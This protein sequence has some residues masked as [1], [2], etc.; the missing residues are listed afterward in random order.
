MLEFRLLHRPVSRSQPGI[1]DA[2]SAANPQ[3]CP[4]DRL[5]RHPSRSNTLYPVS[6]KRGTWCTRNFRRK[7]DR[8]TRQNSALHRELSMACH[9][10]D[11]EVYRYQ[12]RR[13]SLP[14]EMLNEPF[15]ILA[16][17]PFWLL[18]LVSCLLPYFFPCHSARSL[19]FRAQRGIY[20]T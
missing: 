7:H 14:E 1:P 9:G 10:R 17:P 3:P 15:L 5:R 16:L 2:N 8:E 6:P 20:F 4:D 11:M 18:H 13:S 19:S 12:T